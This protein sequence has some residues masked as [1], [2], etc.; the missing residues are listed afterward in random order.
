[1]VDLESLRRLLMVREARLLRQLALVMKAAGSS[2]GFFDTW[3]KQQSDLVQ[4]AATAY[5]GGSGL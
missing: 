2:G 4:G 3:M 5:A 1:M